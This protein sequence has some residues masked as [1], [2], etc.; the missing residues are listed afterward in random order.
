MFHKYFLVNFMVLAEFDQIPDV[1]KIAISRNMSLCR[2]GG[3]EGVSFRK[4]FFVKSSHNALPG[5]SKLVDAYPLSYE[6][7]TFF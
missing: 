6:N 4:F 1:L 7:V 2:L 5:I 3:Q